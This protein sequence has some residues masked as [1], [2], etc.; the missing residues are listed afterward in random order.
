M[1]Q[2]VVPLAGFPAASVQAKAVPPQSW[3]SIP[4]CCL[5]QAHSVFES[6]ALKKTPP[7]PVTLRISTSEFGKEPSLACPPS[8]GEA[9]RSRDGPR[10]APRAHTARQRPP[11]TH[12]SRPLEPWLGALS[13]SEKVWNSKERN[14]QHDEQSNVGNEIRKDHQSKA[15]GQWHTPL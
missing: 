10:L 11:T 12:A 1:D 2:T 5:Y 13:H 14:P 3:T 6:L 7:I 4:R 9:E 15:A 8:N